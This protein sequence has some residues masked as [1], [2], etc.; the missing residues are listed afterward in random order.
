M[1]LGALLDAGLDIRELESELNKLKISGY[2]IKAE[3]TDKKGITGTKFSV[4]VTE[5]NAERNLA[6]IIKLVDRSDLDDD[7]KDLSQRA[8]RE[9]A[10]VEAQIHGKSIDEVHFHEVGAVDALADVVGTAIALENLTVVRVVCSPLPTG[11]GTVTCAHGVLP[12]PAP[13]V[14]FVDA[15][16]SVCTTT[17][18]LL[19][20]SIIGLVRKRIYKGSCGIAV[21]SRS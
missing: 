5:Q 16:I 13:A 2:K 11:S 4:D 6:D 1:I 9:L 21:R 10:A 3:K 12:V 20:K 18:C 19:F 15:S 17:F 14:T 7:I 8:F